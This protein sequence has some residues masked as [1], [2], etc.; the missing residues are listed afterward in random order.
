MAPL[1]CFPGGILPQVI[2]RAFLKE[3]VDFLLKLQ[4]KWRFIVIFTK[5]TECELRFRLIKGNPG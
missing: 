3:T 1:P 4:T 5:K 2:N